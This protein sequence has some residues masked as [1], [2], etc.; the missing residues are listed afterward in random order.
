ME[1]K[2]FKVNHLIHAL[3]DHVIQA[4][5]TT[6]NYF[7]CASIVLKIFKANERKEEQRG[8]LS[9]TQI[10]LGKGKNKDRTSRDAT[11]ER[12][13]KIY[14]YVAIVIRAMHGLKKLCGGVRLKTYLKIRKNSHCSR[15]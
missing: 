14:F 13:A 9:S 7:H 8:E 4:V 5:C 11:K 6:K 10:G 12:Q 15:H 2:P 3:A 1:E